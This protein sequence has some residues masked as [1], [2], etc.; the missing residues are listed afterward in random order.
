[1]A[2]DK[3]VIKTRRNIEAAFLELLSERP[4]DEIT[5]RAIVERA[6]TVKG[7]FYNHYDDKYDLARILIDR[8]VAEYHDCVSSALARGGDARAALV[9]AR[10][11]IVPLIPRIKLLGTIRTGQL[12]IWRDLRGIV[13]EGYRVL[14][15]RSGSTDREDVDMQARILSSALLGSLESYGGGEPMPVGRIVDNLSHVADVLSGRRG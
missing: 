4:F 13:E 11:G 5:V 12:D 7:T 6:L 1:M 14:A 15:L 2:E 3:R 9:T 8:T 10:E